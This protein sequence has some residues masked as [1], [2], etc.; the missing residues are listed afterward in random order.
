MNK[1]I[2]AKHMDRIDPI[3]GKDQEGPSTMWWNQATVIHTG[4][5]L[6]L[7]HKLYL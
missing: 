1:R 2:L 4:N 6:L 3:N 7:K 5:W